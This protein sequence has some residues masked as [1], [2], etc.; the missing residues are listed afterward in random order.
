MKKKDSGKRLRLEYVDLSKLVRWSGNPKD[1]DKGAINESIRKHGFRDPM[2]LDESTG[3]LVAGH[4]RLDTLQQMKAAGEAAPDYIVVEGG[5]W[6]VPII[7]SD[8]GDEL[9]ARSYIIA[10]NRINELGGWNDAELAKWLSDLAAQDLLPGTG[11]DADDLD[12]LLKR[13]ASDDAEPPKEPK[14]LGALGE[15]EFRIVVECANEQEQATLLERFEAQ[16]L[17]VKALI[18]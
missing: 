12:D 15:M 16:G 13:I 3:Q 7:M 2:E 18:S 4:G 10:N 5:A 17:K 11:Y 14:D 8:F 1:H 9:N 6:L